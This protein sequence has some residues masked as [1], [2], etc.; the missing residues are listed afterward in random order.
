MSLLTLL[1]K[2]I[3][4]IS[5]LILRPLDPILLSYASQFGRPELSPGGEYSAYHRTVWC[6]SLLIVRL[7]WVDGREG[8]FV[9]YSTSL[10]KVTLLCT[11]S[12][13]SWVSSWLYLLIIVKTLSM[14]L[15][16]PM[17]IDCSP[18]TFR[19]ITWM[20]ITIF[21]NNFAM[22]Y[23]LPSREARRYFLYLRNQ[24]PEQMTV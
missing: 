4:L 18:I 10:V 21:R 5:S 16:H 11:E 14:F 12:S 24:E 22:Q 6:H 1:L 7:Q 17:V 13:Y 3:I 23:Q 15:I 2:R 20:K 9:T 19:K 8:S